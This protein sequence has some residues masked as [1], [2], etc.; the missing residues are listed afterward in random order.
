MTKILYKQTR[1]DFNLGWAAIP[2]TLREKKADVGQ[3]VIKITGV[4]ST[5]VCLYIIFNLGLN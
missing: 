4:V 3:L 5:L 2:V 1:Q